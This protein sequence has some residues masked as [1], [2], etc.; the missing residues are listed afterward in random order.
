MS[1]P[2]P[3]C[4]TPAPWPVLVL[5]YLVLQI[6]YRY[7]TARSGYVAEYPSAGIPLMVSC[8]FLDRSYIPLGN[9]RVR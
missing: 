2:L 4:G 1:L 5:K 3:R 6:V 9:L 8:C 7:R